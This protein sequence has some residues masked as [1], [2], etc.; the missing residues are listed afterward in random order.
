MFVFRFFDLDSYYFVSWRRHALYLFSFLSLFSMVSSCSKFVKLNSICNFVLVSEIV[1]VSQ[2]WDWR[3]NFI[4]RTKLASSRTNRFNSI[5]KVSLE[6]WKI[7][8]QFV[9]VLW[10]CY[11]WG[12]R[13]LW[14]YGSCVWVTGAF[15]VCLGKSLVVHR[16]WQLFSKQ[17]NNWQGHIRWGFSNNLDVVFECQFCLW[18]K[19]SLDYLVDLLLSFDSILELRISFFLQHAIGM[20]IVLLVKMTYI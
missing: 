4:L 5:S 19:S 2:S 6:M 7:R 17:L 8:W 3:T 1:Y 12:Y 18:V 16:A 14:S 9:K 13:T 20:F 11:L 10:G 15:F